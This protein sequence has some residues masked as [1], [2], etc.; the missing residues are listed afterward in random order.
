MQTINDAV[1]VSVRS[2]IAFVTLNRP[3]AMNAINADMREGLLRSLP[4]LDADGDVKA[5][6]LT[7]S[8]Q[9]AFCAGQDLDESAATEPRGL[10]GWLNHQHAMYQAIRDV[11]KPI[12]AALNGFAMGGGFQMAL[13]CD[14]RVAHPEVRLGQPEVKVGLGSIVG[15]YLISLQVGHSVNQQ[16]SLLG[17]PI[18]GARAGE[19]GL[20]NELAAAED[21]LARAAELATKL[22]AQPTMG[23]RVTKQRFRE[24]TQADFDEACRAGIRYQLECYSTGEPQRTMQEFIARRAQKR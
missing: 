5:L 2:G 7:G 10:A 13:L 9:R 12:V 20:V 16:L 23:L 21:V 3:G 18:S 22:A 19:L 11:D 17:D 15:S 1:Q 14:L 6:V 4:A 24:R 8:G